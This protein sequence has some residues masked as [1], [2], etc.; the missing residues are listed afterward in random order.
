[1]KPTSNAF[2]LAAGLATACGQELDV[3]DKP[4]NLDPGSSEG[5]EGSSGAGDDAAEGASATSG[6]TTGGPSEVAPACEFASE[7][8]TATDWGVACGGTGN[9]YIRA[10]AVD[11]TGAIYNVI[12]FEGGS[13]EA[14]PFGDDEFTVGIQ[15]STL[16]NKISATGEIL[17]TREF[18]GA[19]TWW[20]GSSIAA[21]N[22]R[23]FVG[24]NHSG[25]EVLDFGTGPID[26]NFAVV[27]LDA[28][29]DTLWA[30]ATGQDD[31]FSGGFPTGTVRCDDDGGIAI[32][33]DATADIAFG[34]VMI[35]GGGGNGNIAGYVVALDHDGN[36][37][38]G[39]S[40]PLG[41]MTAARGGSGEL[42]TLAHG[43]GALVLTS[44]DD[45][46]A[47]QWQ[48]EFPATGTVYATNTIID[49]AGN[50]I[51]SGVFTGE[52]DLGGVPLVN[53]DP[54]IDGGFPGQDPIPSFDGFVAAYAADGTHLWSLALSAGASDNAL[55]ARIS[56]DGTPAVVWGK[57]TSA[58]LV[59]ID[60][61]TVVPL[62]DLPGSSATL[63]TVT[64]HANGGFALG[65]GQVP[66]FASGLTARGSYDMVV[67]RVDL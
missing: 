8:A 25:S 61:G 3:G 39:A 67:T 60:G 50:A 13:G 4:I 17:W 47:Q 46:G 26:G 54:P 52:L 42:V 64:G 1:M 43:P 20:S 11:G 22:D 9:E 18:K 33:G 57:E 36:A 31:E 66:D 55:L 48:E 62:L 23:V 29:G 16:V 24:A 49:S 6:A 58:S 14:V 44:R 21:C 10:T 41:S 34:D 53:T 59:S 30:M 35:S 37:S 15:P 28:D 32:H 12:Q 2:L 45:T 5:G 63:Q 51:I 40:S 27:A 38:W 65:Y 56:A 7:I 19:T